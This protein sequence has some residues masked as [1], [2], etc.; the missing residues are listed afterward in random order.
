[1]RLSDIVVA[2]HETSA[3]ALSWLVEELG[4]HPDVRNRLDDELQS[5][6]PDADPAEVAALPYLEAVCQEVLRLHPPLVVL[7]RRVAQPLEP[8]GH[9]AERGFGVSMA[10]RAVHTRAETFDDPLAF[11]PDR[12]LGKSYAAHEF[13]PFGGGAKRCIGAAFGMMEMKQ[14]AFEM[15]RRYEI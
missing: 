7:T 5:L 15:L 1:D 8:R 13:L 6:H 4:R 12:F 14:I 10:V 9:V 2:G 11:R 3:V